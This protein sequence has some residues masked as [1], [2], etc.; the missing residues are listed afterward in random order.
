MAPPVDDTVNWLCNPTEHLIDEIDIKYECGK[1]CDESSGPESAKVGIS[2]HKSVNTSTSTMPVTI[3]GDC[4]SKPPKNIY[5][6][7]D[8]ME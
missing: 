7:K 5:E 3:L 1:T 2:I 8:H 6:K 4:I